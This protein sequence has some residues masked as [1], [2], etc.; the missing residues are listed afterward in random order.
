MSRRIEPFRPT[1]SLSNRLLLVRHELGLSQREA[2]AKCG[3]GF[4]SWQSWENGRSP[5]HALR[6][7]AKVA[8]ALDIDRDWLFWGGPLRPEA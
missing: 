1:D 7:L 6:D 8:E 3:V 5:R 2:A 4:G